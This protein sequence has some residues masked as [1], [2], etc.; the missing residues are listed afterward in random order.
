MR[1]HAGTAIF[2]VQGQRMLA[3]YHR[4]AGP[5][6]KRFPT[7]LFLHGFP[8]SEKS[9]DLQ[10]FLMERGI[11][12]VAPSFLGAWG[13]GGEYRF[14]TLPAQARAA[15]RAAKRMDFVDP[16]R[17]AVFGFSMGGWAALNLAA[18][19]P[20]LRAVV[21]VAPCGGPEMLGPGT[22]GFI[23][24]LSRPLNAPGTD[25]LLAD[26]RA[27]LHRFDPAKA[28]ARVAAPLL[29][30]HGDA[31]D[32]IPLVVSKRLASLAPRGT[33]LV[34]VKGGDH[35]FLDGRSG[36]VKTTGAWLASRV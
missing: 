14:T 24:R 12:S 6:R 35:G 30:V 36:L 25:G 32:T 3:S 2:R 9:V 18:V 27:A 29:L 16:K 1:A 13:S 28:V 34:V 15:L 5:A 8:G 31:D 17:V 7:V 10:R 4:P 33:R 23:S 19:E 20:S 26:F 21:A 11:A 22:R